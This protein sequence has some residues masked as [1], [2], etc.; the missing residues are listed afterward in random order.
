MKAMS[1][2]RTRGFTLVELLVATFIL[3]ILGSMAYRGLTAVQGT[4]RHLA[5]LGSRWQD[6]ARAVERLGRDLR[7]AGD[8]PGRD[9]NGKPSPAFLGRKAGAGQGDEL[10]QLAFTRIGGDGLDSRRVGFRL[11]EGRLELLVWP[12]PESSGP[13]GSYKL[14]DGV[15]ALQFAYLDEGRNWQESWPLPGAKARP[16]AVRISLALDEGIGI[17]RIFDLP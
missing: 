14:L 6:I 11:R 16:R 17:E 7:Q 15:K 3:A 10:P 8:R 13:T 12:L 5:G 9:G 4:E 2:A 1:M